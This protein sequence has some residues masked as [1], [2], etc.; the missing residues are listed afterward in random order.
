MK[1]SREILGFLDSDS[2]RIKSI[3]RKYQIAGSK[4]TERVCFDFAVTPK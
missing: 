2:L 1:E 3:C 4:V